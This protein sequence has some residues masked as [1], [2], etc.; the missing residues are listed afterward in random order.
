MATA[1][2]TLSVEPALGPLLNELSRLMR[3]EFDRRLRA[4]GVA[5][6]RAQWLTLYHVRRSPGCTQVD[7]ANALELERMTVGRHAAR[8]EAEG[9]LERR[10]DRNDGRV[11]RL[12]LRPKA[13]RALDELE[14]I[15]TEMRREYFSGIHAQRRA[16]LV[17][18]LLTIRD[19]LDHMLAQ[20]FT[21]SPS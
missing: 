21:L 13:E 3:Q 18:D 4:A 20:D 8:L 7:L 5:L 6:T 12:H 9:W 11:V 19:N 17:E 15:V 16:Q 1:S 14:P 10:A 2:P